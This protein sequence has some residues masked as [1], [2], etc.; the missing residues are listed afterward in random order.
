M[1]GGTRLAK[2]ADRGGDHTVDQKML[3][4]APWELICHGFWRPNGSRILAGNLK[5]QRVLRTT[6]G[7]R[8]ISLIVSPA[9]P[10]ESNYFYNT[11]GVRPTKCHYL[12]GTG[13][14]IV[15]GHQFRV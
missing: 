11:T 3:R 5:L 6:S 7:F 2:L 14:P 9:L 1:W 10:A 8:V 13:G 12:V 15:R 4:I